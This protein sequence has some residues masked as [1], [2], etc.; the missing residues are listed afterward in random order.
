MELSISTFVENEFFRNYLHITTEDIQET[1]NCWNYIRSIS[2]INRKIPYWFPVI[3]GN[4][5][6]EPSQGLKSNF[7]LV[8]TRLEKC[9]LLKFDFS[10]TAEYV[11]HHFIVPLVGKKETTVGILPIRNQCWLVM[12]V[13]IFQVFISFSKILFLGIKIVVCPWYSPLVPKI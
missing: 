6:S 10:I 2:S 4:P 8:A 9:S 7:C 1:Q 5:N 13:V 12:D 3:K 11:I